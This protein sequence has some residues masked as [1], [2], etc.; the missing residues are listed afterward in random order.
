MMEMAG[1]VVVLLAVV[2][3]AVLIFAATKPDRFHIERTV[4][5]HAPAERIYPLIENF[6]NW[7]KW[8][9]YEKLDPAMKKSLSGAA[10][11][12]GAVYGWE[13]KGK[14]GAGR[15]EITEAE[16]ASKILIKL[17]FTRPM[18]ASNVATF[19]LVPTGDTVDVTWAMDGRSSYLSKVMDVVIGLDKMVGKDFQKG[20]ETMKTEAERGN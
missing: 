15:M 19:S 11:G 8:S 1:F 14:A 2:V 18:A 12:V 13:S 7:A 20:L 17:D 3:I 10:S 9:P 16:P 4:S 5:I 6:S